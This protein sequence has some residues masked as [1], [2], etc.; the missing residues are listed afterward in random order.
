MAEA[1]AL[2][3]ALLGGLAAGVFP[4]LSDALATVATSEATT[5]PELDWVGRY[6]RHYRRLYRPAYAALRPLHQAVREVDLQPAGISGS[7]RD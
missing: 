1:T 3:A 2:G 7:P 6:D 5:P 4:S